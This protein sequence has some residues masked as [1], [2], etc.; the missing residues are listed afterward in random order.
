VVV[1]GN[2]DGVHVGHQALL[3]QARE[4]AAE[5]GSAQRPLQVV[6][7]TFWP[8]PL[9]VVAPQQ[10]PKL[11]TGLEDRI[12]LL[13]QAGADEVRV[14]PFNHRVA[15]WSPTH[16]VAAVLAPLNPQVVVVGAN[17]TFGRRA[18]GTVETL[19]QLAEGSFDVRVLDLVTVAEQTT[20]STL[21]RE[22]LASG[23]V[24]TAAQ[25]LGRPFRVRGVVV[26]GDQRGR[27]LGFPTAN[28][29]IEDWMAAPADGVYAGW[30]RRNGNPEPMP[31]A[32]SVGTN[33]TFNGVERRIESYVMTD[34]NLQL[35]GVE[36]RV[37]FVQRIRGMIRFESVDA[38]VARMNDDVS[39]VRQALVS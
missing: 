15:D 27:E 16:F 25:N 19:Q 11:L 20:C 2:F 36:C 22:A 30:L 17:F 7:V 12:S 23:D 24:Q 6:V 34:E 3:A 38:L 32:I 39:R 4:L 35:Y 21:I 8:H 31:A 14:V 1:I 28:L 9:T 26:M 33:P 18:S 37:D 29:P 5:R 13:K 10:A